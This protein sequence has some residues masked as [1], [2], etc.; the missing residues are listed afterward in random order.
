MKSCE[1]LKQDIESLQEILNDMR[2]WQQRLTTQKII[3]PSD[4]FLTAMLNEMKEIEEEIAKLQ[5]EYEQNC[6]HVI[7]PDSIQNENVVTEPSVK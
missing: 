3:V 1:A 5:A 6:T 7:Q 2:V 4:D